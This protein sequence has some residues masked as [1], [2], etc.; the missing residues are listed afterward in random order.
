MRHS[1]TDADDGNSIHF[2]G[3]A[4]SMAKGQFFCG[5]LF[6]SFTTLF[7]Q[8]VALNGLLFQYHIETVHLTQTWADLLNKPIGIQEKAAVCAAL[9]VVPLILMARLASNGEFHDTAVFLSAIIWYKRLSFVQ[10]R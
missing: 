10:N 5:P 2:F 8:I 3:L 7:L 9:V 1:L 6:F 4:Y